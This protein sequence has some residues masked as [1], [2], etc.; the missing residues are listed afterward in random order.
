ML[1][2]SEQLKKKENELENQITLY[3]EAM[4]ESK[5]QNKERASIQYTF[6]K[7]FQFL[8]NFIILTEN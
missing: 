5:K 3:K 8:I 4:K 2:V 6:C 1:Q 7:S